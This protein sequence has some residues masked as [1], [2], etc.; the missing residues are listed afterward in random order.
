MRGLHTG[1]ALQ[2]KRET[3]YISAF[4]AGIYRY[5]DC[6]VEKPGGRGG[7]EKVGA[8]RVGLIGSVSFYDDVSLEGRRALILYMDDSFWWIGGTG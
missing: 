1:N 3:R 5:I 7:G 8:E 4:H 6:G 2:Q